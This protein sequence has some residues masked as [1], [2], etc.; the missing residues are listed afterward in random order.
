MLLLLLSVVVAFFCYKDYG[1]SWDEPLQRDMGCV[2]YR[3]AADHD[4]TLL[5]YGDQS[6]GV[7]FEIPLIWGEQWLHITDSRKLYLMRHLATHLFFLF[8]A[9]CGYVLAFRLFRDQFLAIM[10]YMLLAFNPRLYA[11]SFFNT[12]DIP[13][14]SALIIV[15]LIA[16]IAFEK[17]RTW[18]YVLLG[19]VAA[20]AT[21]IRAMGIML[22][23]I[24]GLFFLADI[25]SAW[26]QKEKISRGLINMSLFIVTFCGFL[27]ATWPILW[28]A[29]VHQFREQFASLSHIVW[30]GHVL[31]NGVNYAGDQL[32]WFYVPLWFCITTPVLWLM[33]GIVGVVVF[34]IWFVMKPGSYLQNTGGRNFIMYFICFIVPVASV[35]VLHS[36]N[37]DDWRHLYFIY[38]AFVLF[39]LLALSKLAEGKKRL[40]VIIACFVQLGCT[41][42][43]MVSSHPFEQVYF[44]ALVPHKEEYLRTHYDLDYWGCADKQALEYIA[45]HDTSAKIKVW[46]S[47]NPVANN[48][49]I[50]PEETRNRIELVDSAGE[51]TY[52]MTNFRNHANDYNYPPFYSIKVQNS[53]ILKVYKLR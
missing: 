6:H 30:R 47:L 35:I 27:Y 7:A 11:H 16:Q 4:P 32:P 18:W 24:I 46:L 45:A 48:L 44:N 17:D 34:M 9:F 5:T 31:L 50:L 33:L 3:Y 49:M 29:P 37:Y 2:S 14:L 53:T 51:P 15:F 38:P 25:I 19:L 39:V 52:F 1:V 8:G 40:W 36:V 12:K 20:Y 23:P 28:A 42:L 21:S 13:F 43:F 10:G 41:S 26:R 22:A